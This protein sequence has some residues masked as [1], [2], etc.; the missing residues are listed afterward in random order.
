MT[1][2]FLCAR[3]GRQA[4]T[5]VCPHVREAVCA[6][7]QDL[8]EY[9]KVIQDF[10]LGRPFPYLICAACI[11]AYGIDPGKVVLCPMDDAEA[12]KFPDVQPIC[13]E[14][15][16]EFQEARATSTRSGI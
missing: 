1:P 9:E 16:R 15:L 12:E 8:L 5:L 4:S 6:E 7:S 11:Q 13:K 2:P 14:C 10:P 3:H